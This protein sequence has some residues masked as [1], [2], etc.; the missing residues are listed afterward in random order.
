M[1]ALGR[2]V[3]VHCHLHE[4]YDNEIDAISTLGIDVIAVSDN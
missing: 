1:K 2:I 4:Y 3:D